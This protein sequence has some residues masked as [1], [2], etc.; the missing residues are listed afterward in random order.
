MAFAKVIHKIGNNLVHIGVAEGHAMAKL[1]GA[2]LRK[3]L[4]KFL[5]DNKT[6]MK[7]ISEEL[8]NPSAKDTFV[9]KG[10]DGNDINDVVFYVNK[11]KKSLFGM[12]NINSGL[13]R[14]WSSFKG[15]LQKNFGLIFGRPKAIDVPKGQISRIEDNP[16]YQ[17]AQKEITDL[18]TGSE[19]LEGQLKS[20]QNEAADLRLKQ[21][22]QPKPDPVIIHMQGP[23]F[24]KEPGFITFTTKNKTLYTQHPQLT[25]DR[26][27]LDLL[28]KQLTEVKP[29]SGTNL[30]QSFTE[31]KELVA[32]LKTQEGLTAETIS[33][34]ETKIAE[35]ITRYGDGSKPVLIM[36]STDK[37]PLEM[38]REQI[39]LL[40]G[41]VD[42]KFSFV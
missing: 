16:L 27:H 29:G 38:I 22:T 42:L 39:K 15:W 24:S 8:K 32:R 31:L 7:K 40:K 23:N 1:E 28:E 3:A 6:S 35:Q 41:Q 13:G 26:Y 30:D 12:F 18:K 5:E 2:D 20:A 36:S 11:Q 17:A 14:R 25:S 10:A 37:T 4:W 21:E 19:K 34:Y 9:L 33:Q